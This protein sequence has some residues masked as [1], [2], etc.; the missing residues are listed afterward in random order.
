M[1]ACLDRR[2]RPWAAL[3]VV[4][5]DQLMVMLDSTVVNVALSASPS[6]APRDHGSTAGSTGAAS[7]VE[8]ASAGVSNGFLG[9]ALCSGIAIVID[10]V[11]RRRPVRPVHPARSA[12][13]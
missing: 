11:L 2:A 6:S 5:A 12:R 8:A 10:L 1:S 7:D 3:V 4:G 9:L 13:R